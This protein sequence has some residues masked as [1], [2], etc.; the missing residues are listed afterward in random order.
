MNEFTKER[1]LDLANKAEELKDWPWD[2]S[3][4]K[5][6]LLGIIEKVHKCHSQ[7]FIDQLDLD[8]KQKKRIFQYY[9]DYT[10]LTKDCTKEE[11]IKNIRDLVNEIK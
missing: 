8:Y 10:V 4:P 11:A 5:T 9:G 7:D 3:D 1:L 6:C 2:F